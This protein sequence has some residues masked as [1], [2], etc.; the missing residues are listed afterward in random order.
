MNYYYLIASLPGFNMEDP[1]PLQP[2]AFRSLCSEHLTDSDLRAMD[3]LI[4][5]SGAG[6]CDGFTK[7]WH[8]F[9]TQLRNAITRARASRLG[10]A[11]ADPVSE[12]EASDGRIDKNVSDAFAKENPLVREKALDSFRWERLDELAGI[13]PFAGRAVLAYTLKLLLAQRWA[14]MDAAEGSRRANDTIN[15]NPD[16]NTDDSTNDNTDDNTDDNAGQMKLEMQ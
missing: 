4:A 6:P 12:L 5:P 3:E 16:D 13:N 1:P 9:D 11:P 2:A 7:D 15:R 8:Y 10:R 14:Q